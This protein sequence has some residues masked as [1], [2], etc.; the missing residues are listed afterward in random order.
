MAQCIKHLLCKHEDPDLD[1]STHVK[2]RCDSVTCK[3]ITVGIEKSWRQ[4]H[5]RGL[6]TS[7]SSKKC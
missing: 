5:L 4:V 6:L 1:P 7:L 3:S 2:A